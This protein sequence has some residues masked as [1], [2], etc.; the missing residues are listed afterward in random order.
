MEGSLLISM[1]GSAAVVPEAFLL[2][3]IS[4]GSVHVLTTEGVDTGGVIRLMQELSPGTRVRVTQVAGFKDLESEQDHYRFEEVLYRWM[5]ES[6]PDPARRHVCVSG[7]YK[8]MSAAMAKAAAILGAAEVFHVLA[9]KCAADASGKPQ[10]PSTIPEILSARDGGHLQYVRL[11]REAG[12]P[13]L[14]RVVAGDYP[15]TTTA[16]E[17]DV[18]Q[19]V[20]AP[21]HGLRERILEVSVRAHRLAD[22]WSSVEQMP[23][24]ELATWSRE[25]LAWLEESLD[26]GVPADLQWLKRV[27]KVELH[28]HLGGFATRGMELERVRGSAEQPG[29][30]PAV[31]AI[32]LPADWP[33]PAGPIGLETYRKLGDNNGSGLLRDAGC[34]R[35]QCKD[36]YRHLVEQG[37]V[38]AEVRCSPANYATDG[39]SPWQVLCDIR[40]CFQEAM[41]QG[42]QGGAG[43]CHVNLLVIGT[44]QT[45]GDF[46]AG[47][48]RHL[49][50]AVTAAEVWR[51]PGDCRVVGVDL[52]GFE[53][54][55]TRAHFFREEFVGVHRC[56]LALTVH[57]GENDDAEGI[58][59]AVFDLNARRLGHALSLAE[60]PELMASVAARG[61]AVEMCPYANLQI[62]GFAPFH[63]QRASGGK[64]PAYPLLE[65]LKEGIRA[66][67]N[68]D[69]IGIS[70]ATLTDNL[71]MAARLCPGLT[72]M[73]VLQ[74]QRN[75]L[76]AAFV[77]PGERARLLK[78]FSER[79]P[80]P[81]V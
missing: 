48:A 77:T 8:T 11:G 64:A 45:C 28:C 12:W 60:S 27:P 69:N 19:K 22:S 44:R 4:F 56:G 35:Q 51:T 59:S 13:Q 61:I 46:R 39:R 6:E 54:T 34:L 68:T 33:V 65:Y 1:G 53:D 72:R 17:G 81:R 75:A 76:D 70:G 36:L 23:F 49:A 42:R 30:L 41:E 32:D 18:L 14:R 31:Q 50:L 2:P 3:G 73:H 67:V 62:Q 66:T 26:P 40:A 21:N 37:V 52:A 7:G 9:G 47:I 78:R 5:L 24:A 55:S 29:K 25:D 58:W 57:A 63:A 74:L 20:E 10:H 71:A 43:W 15:L 38:Y 79:L 80:T 16:A